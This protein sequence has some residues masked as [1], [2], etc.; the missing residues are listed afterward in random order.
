MSS[1]GKDFGS[2]IILSHNEKEQDLYA[3]GRIQI[4][5]REWCIGMGLLKSFWCEFDW[6]QNLRRGIPDYTFAPESIF[7][8]DFLFFICI[9]T[10]CSFTNQSFSNQWNIIL[11]NGKS[12]ILYHC[13]VKKFTLFNQMFSFH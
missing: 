4:K 11:A 8:A 2:S 5:G 12:F 10:H 7:V 3:K 6:I 13:L 9:F 1:N